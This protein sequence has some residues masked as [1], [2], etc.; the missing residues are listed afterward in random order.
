M[1]FGEPATPHA[2]DPD[3][4]MPKKAV[5]NLGLASLAA[6]RVWGM[7]VSDQRILLA[8]HLRGPSGFVLAYGGPM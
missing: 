5:Y 1:Q 6:L 8:S 3:T 4:I 7:A 2:K